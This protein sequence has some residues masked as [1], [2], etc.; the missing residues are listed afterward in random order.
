MI[1]YVDSSALVK[2]VIAEPE[3][4]AVERLITEHADVDDA[5]VSSSLAW[6]EVERTLRAVLDH[7]DP[8]DDI[9]EAVRIALSGIAERQIGSDVVS[10][11]RRI[12]PTVLRSLDAIHLATAVLLDAD[13]MVTYDDRLAA[14]A[15]HNSIDV[16]APTADAS[17]SAHADEPQP[18]S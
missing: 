17:T 18:E 9:G 10:L 8:G 5:L 12:Q 13:A 1:V 15:H 2:R 3:S 4:D 7:H 14:A 6:I 16:V 11:A